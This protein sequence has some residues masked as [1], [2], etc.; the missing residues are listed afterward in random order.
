MSRAV[1]LGLLL[2]LLAGCDDMTHQAK[3]PTDRDRGNQAAVE[4][5]EQLVAATPEAPPPALTLALVRRGREEFNA[6]C[7]PCHGERGDGRGMVV[8]RGF[9]APLSY[10]T[11]QA[12]AL[13]PAD[14]YGIITNGRGVMYS[15]A[16]RIRPADRW[17]IA[18]Y[19]KALQASHDARIADVPA[20]AREQLR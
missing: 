13:G 16:A 18:A 9:P 7:S 6:F 20:D 8:Q 5:P 3:T 14:I 10:H 17:A 15:Y 2:A 1:A 19:V 11:D 4:E 12:R